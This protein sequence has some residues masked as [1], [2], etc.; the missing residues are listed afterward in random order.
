M[1]WRVRGRFFHERWKQAR[2]GGGHDNELCLEDRRRDQR[3]ACRRRARQRGIV[4]QSVAQGAVWHFI[5][6]NR[7][8]PMVSAESE[9]P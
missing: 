3:P 9:T 7:P 4:V 5:W 1:M 2:D 8:E 6:A